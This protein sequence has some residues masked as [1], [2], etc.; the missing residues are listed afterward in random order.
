MTPE[1]KAAPGTAPR[2]A[3]KAL[4][5]GL[6]YGLAMGLAL[7]PFGLWALV[8]VA[9]MPLVWAA[10][11]AGPAPWRRGLWAALGALPFW[12]YTLHW[13]W[14]V[15]DLGF[16]PFCLLQASWTGVFVWVLARI[17]TTPNRIERL[18]GP[19]LAA[20]VLWTGVEFFRGEICFD[21][22]AWGLLAHPLVDMPVLARAGA[23]LGVYFVSFLACVPAAALGERLCPGG[24][25]LRG[26]A[27]LGI[28]GGA[29]ASIALLP[30]AAPTAPASLRVAVVQTNVPQDNK[31]AWDPLQ[32]LR[33]FDRFVEFT[34]QAARATPRPDL[35][36]WPE[37]MLPGPTLEPESLETLRREGVYETAGAPPHEQKI[38]LVA[39]ADAVLELQ[40]ELGVRML[41]G[42]EAW[43]GLSIEQP[44]SGGILLRPARR[45]NSVY[46]LRD[47]RVDGPR[48]DKVRLT[49]F[50]EYMPYIDAWPWL[51]RQVLSVAARGMA[52]NLDAGRSLTVFDVPGAGASARV[53]TPICFEGTESDLCRRM[54][55]S[56]G[57]RRADLL[58]NLTND[59]WFGSSDLAREQH[60]QIARWRCVELGVPLVRAANTGVSAVVDASGRVVERPG[61]GYRTD[62]VLRGTVEFDPAAPPTL[63]ARV[64]NMFGAAACAGA[65]AL[66]IAT[67]WRRSTQ[68]LENHAGR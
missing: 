32:E 38:P 14:A 16:A 43:T 62:G 20:P 28:A 40:K 22:F 66:S 1:A 2:G 65:G 37:T 21:G 19:S 64:G 26:L 53:V 56:D 41:I 46:L 58:V 27:T 51:K 61:P 50:G 30:H 52:F 31:I 3:W 42:E 59:G 4:A 63:F 7:P 68:K 49:P 47:G 12:A 6:L 15:T 23:F 34:R 5:A 13:V 35:I 44:A 11:T 25:R 57:R 48:Y 33:D 18:L 54:V 8:F 17:T 60:L 10:T 67:L 9:P 39:F 45:F 55:Y 36:I 29:W 24:S